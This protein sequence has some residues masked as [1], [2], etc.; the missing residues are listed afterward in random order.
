MVGLVSKVGLDLP[1]TEIGKIKIISN[2]RARARSRSLKFRVWI[3]VPD[4]ERERPR[5]RFKRPSREEHNMYSFVDRVIITMMIPMFYVSLHLSLCLL[6]IY[7][8]R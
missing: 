3:R 5:Q 1:T 2:D 4:H 6:L 7:T 8:A